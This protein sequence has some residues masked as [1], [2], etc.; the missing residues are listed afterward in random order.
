[1][2]NLFDKI[3]T[4]VN[5]QVNDIRGRNPA[6]PLARI[7]LNAKDAKENPQ[8]T[9]Q[10]LRRRLNEAIEY[11]GELQEKAERIMQEA[12]ELDEK[13]DALLRSG[14]EIGARHLQGQLN[15]RQQ[16]LTIAESELRDH[17]LLT[18]HLM[19][20][21]SKLE[22]ALDNQ[23]RQAPSHSGTKSGGG[24]LRIPVQGT[25]GRSSSAGN[26][27]ASIIGAVSEKL[28]DARS[29]LESLL[30]NSPVPQ[31]PAAD[32]RYDKFEVMDEVPDPRAPKPS[33]ETPSEM[34][35]RLSRL[36]KPDDDDN[37]T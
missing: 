31:P 22:A 2:S 30:N 3:S 18:Q 21:M 8:H 35:D 23:Q 10:T 29:G 32:R 1:M 12:L 16:Q 9:A 7:R 34:S 37:V 24:S 14:D 26:K 11:E 20:E 36:S 15:M 5:A 27:P 17:R 13:V 25:S 6:S 28:E 4:L 33:K 19:Q